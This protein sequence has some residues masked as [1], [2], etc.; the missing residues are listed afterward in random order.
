MFTQVLNV[1]R[2]IAGIVLILV[3]IAA[4]FTP[5]TPGS[6]LAVFGLELLGL[7]VAFAKRYALLRGRLR[8]WR[9][10]RREER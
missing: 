4:F 8:A 6:W 9:R 2:V 1:L 5:L 3:G 7:R 10:A